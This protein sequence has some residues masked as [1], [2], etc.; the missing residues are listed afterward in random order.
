MIRRFVFFLMRQKR[1]LVP[2]AYLQ[3]F[4]LDIHCFFVRFRQVTPLNGINYIF[5]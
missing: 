4:L 1:R 2:D 3:V 5:Y